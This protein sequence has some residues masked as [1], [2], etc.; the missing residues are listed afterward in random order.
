VSRA[1]YNESNPY[2]ARW[3]ENLV[4]AGL[5]PGGDVDAR[6]ICDV[7]PGDLAGYAQCHFFAGIGGWGYAARLAGWPDDRPIWTGSPPCQPWSIAGPRG[8]TADERHLWPELFRL[9]RAARPA[10]LMGEQVADAAGKGWLDGVA[11]DLA[12]VGYAFRAVVLPACSV[13]ALHRRD[14]LYFVADASGEGLPSAEQPERREPGEPAAEV[15]ET[16][17]ERNRGAPWRTYR[18]S[19]GADGITRMVEPGIRLLAHGIPARVDRLGAFGNAIV[20]QIGAEVIAA[21]M[22]CRP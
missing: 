10:V 22:E 12:R 9:A 6:S 4:S 18:Q 13:G 21:Y 1:Y 14:R 17:P 3:L 16:T 7:Q 11:G 5:I 8:G 19:R 15:G 2:A 20:P